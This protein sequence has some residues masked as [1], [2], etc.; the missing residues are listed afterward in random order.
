[1]ATIVETRLKRPAGAQPRGGKPPVQKSGQVTTGV[2]R[3]D[4]SGW[5]PLSLKQEII[6]KSQ[7]NGHSCLLPSA[8]ICRH[9]GCQQQRAVDSGYLWRIACYQLRYQRL[10]RGW[11]AHQPRQYATPL[12][13]SGSLMQGDSNTTSCQP[14]ED[15]FLLYKGHC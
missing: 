14:Q 7:T 4:R 13:P 5:T 2:S 3:P 15:H 12:K 11:A 9:V 6:L 10:R 8:A 1:M